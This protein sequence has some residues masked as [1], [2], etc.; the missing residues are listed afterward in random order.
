MDLEKM[1]E[2][3]ALETDS[4]GPDSWKV[5]DRLLFTHDS[6]ML[7]AA[8]SPD[9]AIQLWNVP[10]GLPAG[11]LRGHQGRVGALALSSDGLMLASASEMSIRLWN[12]ATRTA[13]EDPVLNGNNGAIYALAFSPDGKTLAAGS[14]DGPIKLWNIPGRQE[15][16]SLKVHLS[17]TMDLAF[18]PDGQTL[19]SSSYDHTVRLWRAP[20]VAETD[21]S[22]GRLAAQEG[23]R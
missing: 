10:T 14:L 3:A 2:L 23:R 7:I 22:T 15:I 17:R 1:R 4:K 5:T 11:W 9:G 21:A 16:G 8:D 19:A 12:L 18:S 6:K 13:A 20:T